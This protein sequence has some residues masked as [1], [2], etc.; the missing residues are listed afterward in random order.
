[1]RVH[2][3]FLVLTQLSYAIQLLAAIFTVDPIDSMVAALS[4][5]FGFLMTV[6]SLFFIAYLMVAFS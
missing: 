1:M 6:I 5:L 2:T 3:A 4:V